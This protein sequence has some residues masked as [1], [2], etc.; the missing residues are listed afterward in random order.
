[1]M[2]RAAAKPPMYITATRV[3]CGLPSTHSV[4]NISVLKLT[5]DTI[6]RKVSTEPGHRSIV[7][8]MMLSVSDN[9]IRKT[10]GLPTRG[11]LRVCH[12]KNTMAHTATPP[13]KTTRV[14][15]PAV[16]AHFLHLRES[17]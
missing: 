15:D 6:D 13:S 9:F 8:D 1:M 14:S 11:S 16:E 3:G 2:S 5:S 10:I 4:W 7:R 12:M 17:L